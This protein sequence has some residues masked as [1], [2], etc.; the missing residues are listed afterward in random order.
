MSL[1]AWSGAENIAR[2]GGTP[3]HQVPR[4]GVHLRAGRDALEDRVLRLGERVEN[5]ILSGDS[6]SQRRSACRLRSPP[7]RRT[8]ASP[9]ARVSPFSSAM[10]WNAFS[11]TMMPSAV[12]AVRSA[13][14][15]WD[16]RR[17]DPHSS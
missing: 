11:C 15:P 9:E 8:P 14:G 6:G 2:A 5:E 3:G 13:F 4:V 12:T 10:P 7:K 1:V 17:T 16:R